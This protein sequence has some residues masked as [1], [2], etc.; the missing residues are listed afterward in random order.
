MSSWQGFRCLA[1]H[2]RDS[3]VSMK[4]QH[5]YSHLGAL[6]PDPSTHTMLLLAS[7]TG[8][9]PY[10]ESRE[11]HSVVTDRVCS[12]PSG[13]LSNWREG[14][15]QLFSSGTTGMLVVLCH[16]FPRPRQQVQT[17]VLRPPGAQ[18]WTCTEKEL[19]K[20]APILLYQLLWPQS[21]GT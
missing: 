15:A 5:G 12:Y 8:L 16:R 9:V 20:A 21:Q 6:F 17:P 4:C 13:G 2:C 3:A 19:G 7:L 11:P 1:R 14:L 18:A 10:W